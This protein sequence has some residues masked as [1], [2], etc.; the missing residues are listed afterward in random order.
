[1]YLA[2][3]KQS[4]FFNIALPSHSISFIRKTLAKFFLWRALIL[5][6]NSLSTELRI[7]LYEGHISVSRIFDSLWI[8]KLSGH[9]N[10]LAYIRCR[11]HQTSFLCQVFK[12]FHDGAPL[13]GRFTTE[14]RKV[15]INAPH[16]HYSLA[17]S[18]GK[19]PQTVVPVSFVK[20]TK[21]S[22]FIFFNVVRIPALFTPTSHSP[23]L[24]SYQVTWKWLKKFGD[25][26]KGRWADRT[27]SLCLVGYHCAG[28][29]HHHY[30]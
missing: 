24:P 10:D 22:F 28:H 23:H 8:S 26:A 2:L 25:P 7:L 20:L 9:N 12:F 1:M 14:V 5:Q 29:S 19:G 16:Q 6:D 3:V 11:L 4:Y 27:F 17:R 15:N 13:R 18:W 21:S 30:G